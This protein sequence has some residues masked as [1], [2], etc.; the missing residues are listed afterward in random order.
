MPQS[1]HYNFLHKNT[2]RKLRTNSVKTGSEQKPGTLNS[3]SPRITLPSPSILS[4]NTHIPCSMLEGTRLK[5][6][7]Q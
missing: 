6:E 4:K 2:K 5:R 1:P 7:P 3:L